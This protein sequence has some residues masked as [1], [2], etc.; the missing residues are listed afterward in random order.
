MESHIF[1]AIIFPLAASFYTVAIIAEHRKGFLEK[2]MIIIFSSALFFD[3]SGT[4]FVCVLGAKSW[5]P[6]FHALMGWLALLI[7]SIHFIWAFGALRKKGRAMAR[8]HRWSP[9]A[10]AIWIVSF[11]S[12]MPLFASV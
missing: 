8:F 11:I 9:W 4:F 6:N 7:M 1:E 10:W 5:I 12:G 2:W 3:V